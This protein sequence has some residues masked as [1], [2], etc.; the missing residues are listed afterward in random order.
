MN[1]ISMTNIMEAN[2]KK[3]K[4]FYNPQSGNGNFPSKIDGFLAKFQPGY[5]ISLTR[6]I[7]INLQKY[8]H[9]TCLN[10]Y[11]ILLVAG[12]DGTVSSIVN[13]MMKNNINIPLV[14]IPTGT[15]NDYASYFNISANFDTIFQM[16]KNNRIKNV[17]VGKVNNNFFV[18]VCAGG[19]VTTI[20]HK[21][22]TKLKNKLGKIAYYLKGIQEF[23]GFRSLPLRFTTEKEEFEENIFMFMII[24]SDRAGGFTKINSSS[25]IDDGLF[26]LIAIKYGKLYEMSNALIDIFINKQLTNKNIIHH[27][28]SQFKIEPLNSNLKDHTDIDGERGPEYPL[29]INVIPQTLS[30]YTNI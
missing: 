2:M 28:A 5:E 22:E 6:L 7:N 16:I 3:L 24:N 14:I 4:L 23:P 18:N 15:V 26:E 19:F 8:F 30:L 27:R 20:P 10:D 29:T 25:Q 21:T 11:D 12:G 13:A 17:D 1:N 9:E